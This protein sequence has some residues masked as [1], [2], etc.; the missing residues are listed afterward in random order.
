M[1]GKQANKTFKTLKFESGEK[2]D[3]CNTLVKNFTEYFISRTASPTNDPLL[4]ERVQKKEETVEEFVQDLQASV[5]LCDYQ[6]P[7]DQVR[8]PLVC[9]LQGTTVKQN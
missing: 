4:H 3:D 2:D 1:G 7:G 5:Q 8:D 9:G 6:D